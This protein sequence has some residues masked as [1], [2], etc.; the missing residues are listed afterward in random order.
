LRVPDVHFAHHRQIL[1]GF[2]TLGHDGRTQ[3]LRHFQDGAHH[4]LF[5]FVMADTVEEVAVDLD[6]VRLHFGP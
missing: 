1:G 4:V 5:A 2:D 3:V 6:Q